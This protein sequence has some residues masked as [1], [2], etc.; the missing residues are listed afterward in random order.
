MSVFVVQ[1]FSFAWVHLMWRGIVDKMPDVTS[2]DSFTLDV[3]LP[4]PT[5]A[6]CQ[7]AM[8]LYWKCF[9]SCLM[10]S[11]LTITQLLEAAHRCNWPG[12]CWCRSPQTWGDRTE[13]EAGAVDRRQP[14]PQTEGT[15]TAMSYVSCCVNY[16]IF[17]F[18]PT[19]V[20]I[21][22]M[23]PL[24]WLYKRTAVY[25]SWTKMY[26]DFPANIGYAQKY[27]YTWTRICQ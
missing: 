1:I 17:L 7:P 11:S 8:F 18:I 23:F 22:C 24:V 21:L 16:V 27:C 3:N 4:R 26:F 20:L 25:I 13:T 10:L 14:G 5:G 6:C 12:H 19:R 15:Y 9:E 2:C